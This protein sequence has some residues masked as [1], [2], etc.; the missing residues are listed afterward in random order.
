[1]PR[2]AFCVVLAGFALAAC[3]SADADPRAFTCE[4]L[5]RDARARE[6]IVEAIDNRLH[7]RFMVPTKR[8]PLPGEIASY[9]MTWCAN[10]TEPAHDRPYR[11]AVRA[12]G[13]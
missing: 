9:V 4:R 7:G 1:M 13:T 10:S 11:D 6:L 2:R 3:G 5:A 12:L 8:L